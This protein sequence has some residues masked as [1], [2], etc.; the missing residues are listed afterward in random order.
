VKNG[1]FLGR[2]AKDGYRSYE[3]GSSTTST[4]QDFVNHIKRLSNSNT[5]LNFGA[6][7]YR[8]DEIMYSCANIAEMRNIG[9]QPTYDIESGIKEILEQYKR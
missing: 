5:T 7:A 1:C 8:K 2:K 9:W 6:I 4:I 3:V